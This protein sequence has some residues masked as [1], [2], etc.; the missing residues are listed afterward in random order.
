MTGLRRIP[1][2]SGDQRLLETVHVNSNSSQNFR[3]FHGTSRVKTLQTWH[4]YGLEPDV[5]FLHELGGTYAYEDK[6]FAVVPFCP[7]GCFEYEAI[8][9]SPKACFRQVAV[10]LKRQL[11]PMVL[12]TS[13]LSAGVVLQLQAPQSSWKFPSAPQGEGGLCGYLVHHV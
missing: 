8:V 6:L 5:V 3:C 13:V 10:L 2:A 1:R 7:Q 4:T 9:C 11:V 12:R